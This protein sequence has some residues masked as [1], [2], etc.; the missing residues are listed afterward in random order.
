M[1]LY[2]T[3]GTSSL[4]PHIMLH[5]AGLA[6]EKIKVDEH[7]KL[8]DNGGTT[9]RSIPWASCPPLSSMMA[10]SSPRERRLCSTSPTR[11]PPNSSLRRTANSSARSCNR[12]SILLRV[13]YR[14]DA[15]VRSFTQRHPTLR[16]PCTATA[17]QRASGTSPSSFPTGIRAGKAFLVGGRLLARHVELG[18]SVGRR[19]FPLSACTCAPQARGFTTSGSSSLASRGSDPRSL[20]GKLFLLRATIAINPNPQRYRG[21][22]L[23]AKS[24]VRSQQPAAGMNP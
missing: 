2:Y 3:P 22:Y 6:F 9:G 14:W 23:P 7:T 11:C 4:F 16:R 21:R 5:E 10:L 18:A 19:P 20:T 15:S 1:K 17:W 8:I 13:R 24:E 12:G